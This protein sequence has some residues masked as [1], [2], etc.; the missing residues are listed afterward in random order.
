MAHLALFI[1]SEQT[2]NKTILISPHYNR[3]EV[4]FRL[5]IFLIAVYC[6]PER[7]RA[8]LAVQTEIYSRRKARSLIG[9]KNVLLGECISYYAIIA[10]NYT[11]V[12]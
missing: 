2:R 11:T 4:M 9:M 12:H 5:Y 7:A 3:E 1:K 8:L 10:E 6:V